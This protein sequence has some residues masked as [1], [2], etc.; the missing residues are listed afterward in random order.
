MAVTSALEV[1][2]ACLLF[3]QFCHEIGS[4]TSCSTSIPNS[5][6]T[7]M[8]LHFIHRSYILIDFEY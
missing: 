7:Q 4:L 8:S 1:V 5:F 6:P 2:L 3:E